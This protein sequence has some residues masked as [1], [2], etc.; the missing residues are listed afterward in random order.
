[1]IIIYSF[2]VFF[3]TY[4]FIKFSLPYLKINFLDE[5]N[6]RSLHLKPTPKG[7]GIFFS[8]SSG[9][10]LLFLNNPLGLFVCLFQ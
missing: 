2:L 9:L 10:F 7:G 4:I 1:M 6:K 5:P 8:I 3:I